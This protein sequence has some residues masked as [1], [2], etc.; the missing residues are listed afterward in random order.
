MCESH[1]MLQ[2]QFYIMVMLNHKFFFQ[3]LWVHFSKYHSLTVSH[4]HKSNQ[5][6]FLLRRNFR[7]ILYRWIEFSEHLVLQ[8]LFR[9]WRKWIGAKW[10][11]NTAKQ[12]EGRQLQSFSEFPSVEIDFGS[13]SQRQPS[14]S[15]TTAY[16]LVGNDSI[17]YSI[18]IQFILFNHL[19]TI[20]W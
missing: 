6:N 8:V 4:L 14:T 17:V 5:V 1:L 12:C 3:L 13:F 20:E 19:N 18:V 2:H 9:V 15:R 10:K 11:R 7:D 16:T